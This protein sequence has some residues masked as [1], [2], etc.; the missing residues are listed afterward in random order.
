MKLRNFSIVSGTI[1]LALP[2][3][4]IAALGQ[5]QNAGQLGANRVATNLP[6]A[7]T[8]IAPPQGFNPLE[9]SDAELSTYGFPPRPDSALEPKAFATWS[10][11]MVA[12]KSRVLPQLEQTKI[13]HG[14]VRK[15][16]NSSVMEGTG[17]SYNWSGLVDFSGASAY[18]K[19]SSF[20]YLFADYVVPVAR[21]AFGACTGAW[22]YSSSWVGIDGDG[23]SDVLQAGTEA[24][25]YCS[26]S[27]T[28]T[29][30]SAWY[31]WYPYG[32][33]RISNFP[34]SPG[35]DIFVEVWNT[36]ATQGYMYMV[37]YNNNQSV[38]IGFTAYPGY[39]LVGNSAEWVVERPSVGSLATLSNYI[40]DYFSD[41]YAY[42]FSYATYTPG[43][44]S[45]LSLTMLDNSGYNISY[46]TLLGSTG[47]WFQD[48]NSARFA[49]EP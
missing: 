13:F 1:L 20:Y 46:P 27:T 17:Y 10:K 39:R 23:S 8:S 7:T 48:E 42:T 2:L 22:D 47:I 38:E 33:V 34:V 29:Y 18:N 45:A 16:A 26:G 25:A 15:A 14:P 4:S 24:D 19:T 37:N 49:S 5:S 21:Q 43:T 32:S 6:G 40:S 3:M 36:S 28:S 12:S 9:A 11:A 41:C 44:A 35:D 30:Y 31:E